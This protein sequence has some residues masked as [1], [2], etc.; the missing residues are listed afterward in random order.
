MFV[1][2]GDWTVAL[3]IEK[4][5]RFPDMDTLVPDVIAATTTLVLADDDA[6]YLVQTASRL[7]GSDDAHAP[8]TLDLNGAVVVRS[9]SAEQ[10][11]ATDLVLRNSLKRGAE[12]KVSVNREFLKRAVRLG[13][14]EFHLRDVAS[15]AFCRDDRRAYVCAVLGEPSV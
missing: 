4:V 1:R 13:F 6:E 10:Q 5:P 7:P 12:L 11:S 15:P 9:K 2:A 3:K 14:R 8:V